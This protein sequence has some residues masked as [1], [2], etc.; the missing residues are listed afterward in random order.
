MKMEMR[1]L[2]SDSEM[3]SHIF[4]GCIKSEQLISI[5][6]KYVGTDG[7]EIDWRKESVKIPVE[8]KIGGV[9]VNPKKFFDMWR[10]Q[11]QRM[12]L[13]K[14]Q[15]LVAEKLGSRKM[16]DMQNKLY[17]YEEIL[18]SWENDINWDIKNPLTANPSIDSSS[19]A[20]LKELGFEKIT[21]ISSPH[22]KLSCGYRNRGIHLFPLFEATGENSLYFDYSCGRVKIESLNQLKSIVEAFYGKV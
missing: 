4:L 22:E 15:E 17:E 3:M 5:R 11:I 2:M 12:I 16:I 14:A 10:D 21:N 1:E 7:N 6:D 9:A 19:E 13:E 8:M 20:I 18:K